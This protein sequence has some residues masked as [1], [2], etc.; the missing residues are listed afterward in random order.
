VVRAGD[1]LWVIARR[2]LEGDGQAAGPLEVARYWRR[3]VAVN[4]AALR[5]HDPDLIFPGER[6]LLPPR[7]D[8]GTPAG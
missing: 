7:S 4:A 6:I 2:A 3:V 8:A 5:S 1:N